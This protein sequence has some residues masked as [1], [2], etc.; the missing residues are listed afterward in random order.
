MLSLQFIRENADR[1]RQPAADKGIID[2]PIDRIL[3]LDAEHR[4]LLTT[5]EGLR[6]EHNQVNRAA[7]KLMQQ[8]RAGG[9]EPGQ[10]SADIP[11]LNRA[12]ALKADIKE[13]EAK[14]AEVEHELHALLLE[15]PNVYDP[16]GPGGADESANQ[17]IRTWGE[18]PAFAFEPRP[19]YEIGEKLGILDFERATKVAG[20]RFSFLVG[21]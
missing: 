3:E 13:L 11:E 15:V 21:E 1:V 17:E 19:H 5:L 2:A 20:S 14:L 12:L 9:S 18:K 7:G 10:A 16:S 6:A 4:Q 8:A